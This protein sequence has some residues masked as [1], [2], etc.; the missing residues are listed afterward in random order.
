[1]FANLIAYVVSVAAGSS[2]LSASSDSTIPGFHGPAYEQ[3]FWFAVGSTYFTTGFF[4][5]LV[6]LCGIAGVAVGAFIADR[7]RGQSSW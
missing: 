7:L 2:L 1:M 3:I 5:A 4:G 6:L